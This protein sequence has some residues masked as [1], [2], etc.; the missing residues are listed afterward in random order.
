M[1]AG[2]VDGGWE[3]ALLNALPVAVATRPE[4]GGAG[5]MF[6]T[7]GTMWSSVPQHSDRG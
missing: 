1:Q 7:I 4:G 3:G 5:Y 2:W 6:L